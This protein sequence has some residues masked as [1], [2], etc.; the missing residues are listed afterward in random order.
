VGVDVGNE[1]DE[2]GK[3]TT[4]SEEEADDDVS[5]VIVSL[6]FGDSDRRK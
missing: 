5:R 4:F 3:G 6:F 2:V 1:V